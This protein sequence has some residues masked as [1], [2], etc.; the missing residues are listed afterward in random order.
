[1]ILGENKSKP[2]SLAELLVVWLFF[3][4]LIL[5]VFALGRA[6]N[7]MGSNFIYLFLSPYLQTI[8][9]FCKETHNSPNING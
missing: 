4:L 5:R 2:I 1:M 9:G 3:L 7:A 6:R 8:S